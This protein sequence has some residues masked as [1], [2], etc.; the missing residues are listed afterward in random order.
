MTAPLSFAATILLV[1][2]VVGWVFFGQRTSR[3]RLMREFASGGEP[4]DSPIQCDVR[5]PRDKLPSPH[6]LAAGA[7]GLYM[8]SAVPMSHW[9]WASRR[10]HLRKPVL[11]PWWRLKFGPAKFPATNW[12]RFDVTDTRICF[13]VRKEAAETLLAR[14]P[15]L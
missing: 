11:I 12:Y 6:C 3:D 2:M 5:F 14:R 10:H 9:R 7:R 8:A 1:A 4:S 13:F 15:H